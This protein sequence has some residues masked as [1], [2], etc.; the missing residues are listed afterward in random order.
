MYPVVDD[1][2]LEKRAVVRG[3]FLKHLRRT[4]SVPMAVEGT[5]SGSGAV[6]MLLPL[7]RF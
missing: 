5:A 7:E 2:P 3:C 6:G 4:L 1:R